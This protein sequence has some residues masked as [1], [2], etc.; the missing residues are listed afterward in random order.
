VSAS[1]PPTVSK[2]LSDIM[3]GTREQDLERETRGRRDLAEAKLATFIA[4]T[5]DAAP[6]LDPAQVR[7]LTCLICSKA[8]K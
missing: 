3:V 6:P 8:V 2:A 5:L 7:R 4:R 1:E